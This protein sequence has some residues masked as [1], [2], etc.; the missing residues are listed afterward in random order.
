MAL[1]AAVAAVVVGSVGATGAHGAPAD[2]STDVTTLASSAGCGSAPTL[3]SGTHT[4]QSG[5][6]SRSFILRVPDN[7]DRSRAYPLIFAFHWNGGTAGDV[8]GGGTD[9]ANWSYYGLQ[10]LSNNSAIFVAPQGIGNGW[11]NSGGRDVTFVDDMIGRL[12]SGLC[13]DTAQ[14]FALG[15]SYGGGMS[16]SLACSRATVFRA[17]AVYAGGQLSGCSG[18][19]QPI[20]YLGIHGISDNVLNISQGRS[21]RDRFVTNNGCT[22]QNPPEPASGSRTHIVTSYS[23]CR[24]GYPVQW[25]AFDGGHTPGPIDGTYD[26]GWQTWTSGVTWNFFSQFGSGD[27]GGGD[28]GAIVGAQSSRCLDVAGQSQSNGAQ[29]QLWDCNGA[30]NQ[31]WTKTASGE[32]RVYGGKCLDAEGGATAPGTRAII[33]DCHGGANQ[34]WNVNANGTISSTQS[35]LCL[36]ASGNATA[37]GT[38][39]VLW[40]CNGGANQRWTMG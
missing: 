30:A 2:T 24:A 1:L 15:F 12:E 22:R 19:T 35:G 14:R 5:G 28:E 34:K 23:G 36:D 37:N 29:L 16:Y 39:V 3:S 21:L 38:R 27:P 7:Y 6:T 10:R 32:L 25:A 18:G 33:W 17:V 31:Q 13:V 4:I 40:T 11:A 26:D 8:A 20:A 9:G